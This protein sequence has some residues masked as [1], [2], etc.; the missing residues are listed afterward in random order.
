MSPRISLALIAVVVAAGVG[1]AVLRRPEPPKTA[2]AEAPV[3]VQAGTVTQRDMP[4]LI[5]A[6]GT[7]Q[8]IQAVNVQSWVNGQIMQAFFKQGELV[9]EGD[10]LFLIDPRPYQAA[11]DQAQ[12]QLEHDQALLAEAQADLARYQKLEAENSIARQQAEDQAF[13]V[14]QDEGT[15]KLDQ[16]NGEAAKL[17]LEY[18]HINSP[19]TGIAGALQVDPGNYVQAGAGTTLVTINQISPIYVTFPIPQGELNEVGAA[20]KT[21]P[22]DVR[23]L[24]QEG[25]TL[26]EGKLTFINNEVVATTGTVT[27]YATFPNDD[28]A[29]WPGAFVTVDLAVGMRKNALTAPVGSVMSGP[30]GDY[31]YTISADNVVKRAPVLVVA[32]QNGV[33]VFTQGVSLGERVVVNGQYNLANGVKVA[34]EPPKSTASASP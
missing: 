4:I 14:Q 20:Q 34:I 22:L 8:S 9:K 13:V 25:K 6:L 27:L 12:A 11:L 10:P 19:V 29:L 16:A 28:Q 21:A 26:G 2:P 30:E 31:V 24:S 7:V 5:N 1:F 17:N 23:A 15:V 32:R 18:A 33:A 3:P